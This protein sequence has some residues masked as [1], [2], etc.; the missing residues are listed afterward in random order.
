MRK[1]SDE[2]IHNAKELRK[3]D[4]LS[5][6][7]LQKVT[8]IPATT[9]RNWCEGEFVGTKWDILLATNERRRSELRKSETHVTNSLKDITPEMAKLLAAIIYWCEGAKYPS[10]NAMLLVNSDPGLLKVFISLFRQGFELDESKFR[11]RLQV[12]SNQNIKKLEQFWSKLLR[13]STS[14]FMKPTITTARGGKHRN[15]YMGT[16]TIKY[17]DVRIQ[18]KLIG[19]YE[20]IMKI[21]EGSHSGLVRLS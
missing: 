7:H 4:R 3:R 1:Y 11:I 20:A 17:Q 18:L 21:W 9:I 15:Q 12:H 19:I 10:S 2:A 5:F 6:A 13:I 16:C 14:Q 8:G